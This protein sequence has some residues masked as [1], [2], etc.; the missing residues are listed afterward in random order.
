MADITAT[1]KQ[2]LSGMNMSD[3]E[4]RMKELEAELEAVKA[5][6]AETKANIANLK[7]DQKLIE[8]AQPQEV[9]PDIPITPDRGLMGDRGEDGSLLE[10]PITKSNEEMDAQYME[11]IK[12]LDLKPNTPANEGHNKK[13]LHEMAESWSKGEYGKDAEG[14][15]VLMPKRGMVINSPEFQEIYGDAYDSIAAPLEVTITKGADEETTKGLPSSQEDDIE[16]DERT[17]AY[18][19]KQKFMGIDREQG[20]AMAMQ[21][22]LPERSMGFEDKDGY[23]SVNEKDDFWKTQEGYD[24]AIEMYGSK[25][26]WVKEPTLIWN[27]STQEYEEIEEE[28]FEDL[29]R[30]AVSSDIK[31]LFG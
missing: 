25:P 3:H 13:V 30:P 27:P 28:E 26:A 4:E 21:D 29:S 8:S 1:Q 10:V 15:E 11:E 12:A 14:N 24:K 22:D 16:G 20:R 17:D 9:E 18:S 19:E 6:I 5:R 7:A 31:K 23:M 2:A